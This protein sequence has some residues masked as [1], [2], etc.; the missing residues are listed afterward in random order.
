MFVEIESMCK[1]RTFEL[2][3]IGVMFLLGSVLFVSLGDPTQSQTQRAV[4]HPHPLDPFMD[5]FSPLVFSVAAN[6]YEGIALGAKTYPPLAYVIISF[7]SWVHE[8]L[9]AGAL[10][11]MQLGMMSFILCWLFFS[12]LLACL[13]YDLK[14][15]SKPIRF[16]TVC[17]L[18][19]SSIFLFAVERGNVVCMSV[20]ALLFFLMYYRHE[21]PGVRELSYIALAIASGLKICPALFGLLLIYEKR[22]WDAARLLLYGVLFFFLSCLCFQGGL[23]NFALMLRNQAICKQEAFFRTDFVAEYRLGLVAYG[24]LFHWGAK[25]LTAAAYFTNALVVIG[26]LTAWSLEKRWKVILLLSCSMIFAYPY[27]PLYLG[28][29]LF[30]P[31]VLFLNDEKHSRWDWCYLLVILFILNPYQIILP[32]DSSPFFSNVAAQGRSDG[33]SIISGYRLTPLIS[34]FFSIVLQ[35]MLCMEAVVSAGCTL[36]SRRTAPQGDAVTQEVSEG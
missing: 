14:T 5:F 34:N 3:F 21:N 27:A 15:G 35:V 2:V 22:Y 23:S 25:L 9:T 32:T 11:G 26:V 16:L 12:V 28:M 7:F 29:Y 19:T 10:R 1:R 24:V 30:G 20:P 13:L 31:I 6:P 18:L 33:Y 17:A 4:F 8:G 36:F